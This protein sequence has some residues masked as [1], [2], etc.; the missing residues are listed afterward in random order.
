MSEIFCAYVL[1]YPE[2]GALAVHSAL[3]MCILH[4]VLVWHFAS[5]FYRSEVWPSPPDLASWENYPYHFH[6]D[7][8]SLQEQPC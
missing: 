4:A 8:I 3:H 2:E 7:G 5:R 1:K 6:S